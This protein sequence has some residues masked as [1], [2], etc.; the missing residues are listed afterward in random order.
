MKQNN[1][2]YKTEKFDE[3]EML[4]FLI[5]EGMTEE[6]YQRNILVG[7]HFGRI[8]DEYGKPVPTKKLSD[9]Q[10]GWA[11]AQHPAHFNKP[12]AKWFI[13]D[14][15][16]PRAVIPADAGFERNRPYS[17]D[18]SCDEPDYAY[19]DKFHDGTRLYQCQ[20]C[21]EVILGDDSEETPA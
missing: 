1:P 7:D 2:L 16:R 9:D 17:D 15:N 19:W 14:P 18:C 11:K 5:K 3:E 12:R 6:D 4:I 21:G 8:L 13:T 10:R 20:N